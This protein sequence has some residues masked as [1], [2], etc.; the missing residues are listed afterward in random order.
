MIHRWHLIS[1]PL[2]TSIACPGSH[3]FLLCLSQ[4]CQR[5]DLRPRR[6]GKVIG[7][8]D[9]EINLRHIPNSTVVPHY[10]V[11]VR[12]RKDETGD[13]M[14]GDGD[15]C[16]HRDGDEHRHDLAKEISHVA[17]V[18]TYAIIWCRQVYR[19]IV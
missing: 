18:V 13:G 16:G 6:R 14:A 10:E 11:V 17:E 7:K 9:S 15:D 19:N 4:R 1:L 3:S 12:D 5:L 8:R 2:P